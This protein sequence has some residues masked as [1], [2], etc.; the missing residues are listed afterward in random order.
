MR[1]QRSCLAVSMTSGVVRHHDGG[2]ADGSVKS[3]SESTA[4][5]ALSDFKKTI[6]CFGSFING[7]GINAEQRR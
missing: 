6:A 3:L 5:I 2:A 7:A 1:K 4:L